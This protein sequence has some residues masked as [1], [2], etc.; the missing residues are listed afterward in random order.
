LRGIER[1]QTRTSLVGAMALAS[2][3]ALSLVGFA[4]PVE[5]KSCATL[6]LGP[7]SVSPGSGPPSTTFTFRLTVMDKTGATPAWVRLQVNGSSSDLATSGTN[8]KAG[9]VFN[10]QNSHSANLHSHG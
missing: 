10:K 3:M 8:F 7:G 6:T 4:T 1:R 5:A 2:W 9:V